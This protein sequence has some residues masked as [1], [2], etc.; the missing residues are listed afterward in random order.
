MPSFHASQLAGLAVLPLVTGCFMTLKGSGDQG[1]GATDWRDTG[2]A[3]TADTGWW[4]VD[5]FEIRVEGLPLIH[6]H[7]DAG[8]ATAFIRS[9]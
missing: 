5:G 4:E 7:S 2:G 6:N 3:D 1:D 9:H 8:P